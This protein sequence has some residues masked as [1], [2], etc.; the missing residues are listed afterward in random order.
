VPYV[1]AFGLVLAALGKSRVGAQ[2]TPQPASPTFGPQEVVEVGHRFFGEVSHDLA[3]IVQIGVSQWGMPNG[4]VLG[5]VDSP[6]FGAVAQ[7]PLNQQT[8]IPTGAAMVVPLARMSPAR[9]VPIALPA[10]N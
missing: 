3:M 4:Y 5:Q 10:A 7:R 2:E 1:C 8:G 6:P 9:T